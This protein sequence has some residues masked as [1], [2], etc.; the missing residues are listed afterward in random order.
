MEKHTI[1]QMR[2]ANIQIHIDL[3]RMYGLEFLDFYK[4][5]D[6]KYCCRYISDPDD[7]NY[8]EAMDNSELMFLLNAFAVQQGRVFFEDYQRDCVGLDGLNEL[9]LP[10]KLA[11]LW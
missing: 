2:L 10:M 4:D 8:D 9:Y 6:G 3:K 1:E 7:F 11:G 5:K